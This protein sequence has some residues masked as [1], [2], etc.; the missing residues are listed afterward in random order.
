VGRLEEYRKNPC[1]A[2]IEEK[3]RRLAKFVKYDR[4]QKFPDGK[5]R[6]YRILT[7]PIEEIELWEK[8]GGYEPEKSMWGRFVSTRNRYLACM[9]KMGL[10]PPWLK[11]PQVMIEIH[12]HNPECLKYS[13][14]ALGKYPIV[15]NRV[16]A[17]TYMSPEDLALFECWL[18]RKVGVDEIKKI[19]ISEDA[20]EEVKKKAK[21]FAEKHNIPIEWRIPCPSNDDEIHTSM[22]KEWKITDEDLKEIVRFLQKREEVCKSRFSYSP[23]PDS[24]SAALAESID[25][26]I[27]SIRPLGASD[28]IYV[29]NERLR[30]EP[31]IGLLPPEPECDMV[32]CEGVTKLS[33]HHSK[34]SSR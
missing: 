29:K 9:M 15:R 11:E 31:Y 18:D 20:D 10:S 16:L 4:V 24:V 14:A 22:V 8:Y 13:E 1:F 7:S 25:S 12:E 33:N 3:L 34:N 19:Y 26:V 28:A 32:I 27:H 2:K 21:E 23:L 17:D 30:E 5:N 6:L